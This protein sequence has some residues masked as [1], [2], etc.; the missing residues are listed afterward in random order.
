MKINYKTLVIAIILAITMSYV[1]R[2]LL[3]QHLEGFPSRDFL[4][5]SLGLIVFC[6]ATWSFYNSIE[7]YKKKK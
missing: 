5:N 4:P 2:Y 3:Y 6:I 1:I 7:A